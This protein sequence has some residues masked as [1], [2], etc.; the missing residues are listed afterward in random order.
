MSFFFRQHRMRHLAIKL[1]VGGVVSSS[2][3]MVRYHL[4]GRH[5]YNFIRI[6]CLTDPNISDQYGALKRKCCDL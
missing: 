5:F 2:E 4:K 3:L 1:D 6:H